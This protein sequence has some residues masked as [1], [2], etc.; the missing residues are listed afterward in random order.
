MKT[1]FEVGDIVTKR[2]SGGHMLRVVEVVSD[3]KVLVKISSGNIKPFE[4][5]ISNL[6]NVTKGD[7]IA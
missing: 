2:E 7:P 5:D 4:E 1:K 3:T 6:R